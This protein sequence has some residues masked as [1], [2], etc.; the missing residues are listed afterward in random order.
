MLGQP[1]I[2]GGNV[3]FHGTGTSTEGVYTEIG[4]T[5]SRVA[6]TTTSVPSGSG[7]FSGFNDVSIDGASVS[8]RAFS[9]SSDGIY[10]NSGGSL[11]KVADTNTPVPSGSGNFQ[12]LGRSSSSAGTVAFDGDDAL[13]NGIGI[14]SRTGGVLTKVA[15]SN[16]AQ[17][18]GAGSFAQFGSPTLDGS[19]FAFWGRGPSNPVEGI[20]RS[21]GGGAPTIVADSNT[22]VPGAG[23][24]FDNIRPFP[25]ISGSSVSFMA[26]GS[27]GSDGIYRFAGSLST[28]ADTNTPVPGGTGNFVGFDDYSSISGSN[29]AFLGFFSTLSAA[30]EGIYTTIGGGLSEVVKAGDQLDG[31]TVSSVFMGPEAL[32]GG[33]IAFSAAFSD[34]SSGLF[35]ATVPE[36]TG[37]VLSGFGFLSL[38]FLA[39]RRHQVIRLASP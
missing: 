20:Y 13:G 17:P 21:V 15:D 34:G 5:L 37:V 4:T 28:V 3:V 38:V 31:K 25:A 7:N 18:G 39:W 30:T 33:S 9:G 16:T 12:N 36:P 32:S 24:T 35:V 22:I 11:V 6:D 19:N 29:V 8:F 2:D 10:T 27:N 26:Y 23:G 14:Y 1:S